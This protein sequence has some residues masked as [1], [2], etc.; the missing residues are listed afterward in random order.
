M[1]M[2]NWDHQNF[3]I[4]EIPAQCVNLLQDLM[5]NHV[6]TLKIKT[7]QITLR[8]KV[9]ILGFSDITRIDNY[10]LHQESSRQILSLIITQSFI[11]HLKSEKTLAT[12]MKMAMVQLTT[13]P[14]FLTTCLQIKLMMTGYKP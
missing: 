7:N 14:H 2:K 13:R 6:L 12:T 5:K 9:I 10:K 4:K 3:L 11:W 1:K 8:I